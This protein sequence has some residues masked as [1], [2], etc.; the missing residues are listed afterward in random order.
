MEVREGLYINPPV[1]YHSLLFWSWNDLLEEEEIRKQIREFKKGGVGGFFIHS[2]EGLMTEYMGEQWNLC[3]KAAVEEAKKQGLN[4]WLYDEDR[5]PSGGAAGNVCRIGQDAF[6]CKGVTLEVCRI[7]PAEED[8]S[9]I[10]AA[11]AAVI[12]PDN[13]MAIRSVRRISS[14]NGAGL[15]E[16]ESL[17]LARIEISGKNQWF[18]GEA[19]VDVLNPDAVRCFIRETHEKYWNLLGEEFGKTI[20]GIFTDEPSLADRRASFS[21]DRGWMPWTW[22]MEHFFEEKRGYNLLDWLPYLY[23]DGEHCKKIRHDYW[24]TIGERFAVSYTKQIGE[25]CE[26]HGIVFTGHF[27]QEDKLG[28]CTRVNGSVMPHY[29][30]QQMPGIDWLGEQTKEYITVKQCSSVAAQLGKKRVLT[31]TYAGTG[32]EFTLEGQKWVGDFQFVLGINQR[33]MHLAF[34]SLKGMRKRD[35]PPSFSYNNSWWNKHN[36]IEMYFS[37]LS[38]M[39]TQGIAVREILVLHPASTAWSL[40]GTNPY[41]NPVRRNERDVPLID[42]YGDHFNEFLEY[43]CR[44][45][46]DFDLGDETLLASLG[47]TAGEKLIL[48]KSEYRIVIIPPM[49][50]ILESTRILLKSFLNKGGNIISMGAEPWMVEGVETKDIWG[51]SDRYHHVESR[52]EAVT[53]LEQLL[54]RQISIVLPDGRQAQDILYQMRRTDDGVILFLVNN[55]RRKALEVMI[56]LGHEAAGDVEEWDNLSGEKREIPYQRTADGCTTYPVAFRATDSKLYYIKKGSDNNK[57]QIAQENIRIHQIYRFP[58]KTKITCNQPNILVLDQCRWRHNNNWGLKEEVW[59]VQKKIRNILGMRPTHINGGEQWYSW[60]DETCPTDGSTI[61]LEF[62]FAVRIIPEELHLLVERPKDLE[63]I[64]NGQTISNESTGYFLDRSF[65]KISLPRSM[66]G[67]NIIRLICRYTNQTELENCYLLGDFGVS[68]QNEIIKMPETLMLGDWTKQGFPHYCGSVTYHYRHTGIFPNG[69]ILL[70]VGETEA[71]CS[72]VKVNQTVFEV[73]W[74]AAD[75]IDI[76]EAIVKGENKF[77]VEIH[78]TPRNM[79]G[80]FTEYQPGKT[81]ISSHLF[82]REHVEKSLVVPY[83]LMKPCKLLDNK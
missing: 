26:Q 10:I 58:D 25:W 55:N 73:P 42:N 13:S 43:L 67:E 45:H 4:V 77:E 22:G 1:E 12:Q 70:Q 83:G 59:K 66:K 2:R 14:V 81:I 61:E 29:Q 15:R 76:T 28:L 21:P 78:G 33:C 19:P 37:R 32:W 5:W 50:T 36:T 80:P 69:R 63:I 75:C 24:R 17:L 74:R 3:I 54:S 40:L 35:Y 68:P 16:G 52:R 51:E 65:R 8:R 44:S 64:F 20:K 39:L 6:R 62:R 79:L 82:C 47:E 34:Y 46:Y 31:E 23:F 38:L 27:L 9:N 7:Y 18:H 72:S 49:I 57:C 30:Y 56:I 53:C 48:G 41:G 60:K 71:A 11:Y